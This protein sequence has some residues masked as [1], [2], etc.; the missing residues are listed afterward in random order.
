[1]FSNDV[2]ATILQNTVSASFAAR[3]IGSLPANVKIWLY[4]VQRRKHVAVTADGPYRDLTLSDLVRCAACVPALHGEGKLG[5]DSF[6]DPVYAPGFG[7]F[8]TRHEDDG[9]LMALKVHPFGEGNKMV[10]EDFLRLI[11]NR[12][13]KRIQLAHEMAFK[14]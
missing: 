9:K 1:M 5:V 8:L 11:L 3:P 4:D 13:N 10:R 7:K 12:P 6:I 2:L 14:L